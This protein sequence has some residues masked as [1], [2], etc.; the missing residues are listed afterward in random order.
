ME[1][2]IEKFWDNSGSFIGAALILI[3]GLILIKLAVR[4]AKG[5]LE[6]S[7]LDESMYVFVL[8]AL[9]IT[10]FVLLTVV[11]LTKLQVPTAPI[12]TVLGAGSAAIALALKDSL[13]NI[14]GGILILANKPF[15]K[16]DVIDIADING[17]VQH[18]DLF[19]TTLTT[20]DNKI[21]TIP[22]GTINT[23][24]IV[25]YSSATVRRVDC[26]FGIGYDSD[27]AKA[28]DV[29][30]AVAESNPDIYTEPEPVIGVFSHDASA[31]TLDLKVWCD[32]EKYFDVRYYL[33]EQVKLAFDEA[34]ITIPYPQMD[35]HVVK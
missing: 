31:I 26:Q 4:I 14:A 8:N 24:V 16:G 21:I 7:S 35:V 29:L 1:K 17:V 5:A 34:N 20:T 19:V 15:K 25:N 28:K 6:K 3:A 10:L 9:R 18:I 2:L 11:I 22:N 23:S 32:T 27:I 12:V 13:G 30:A 33:Q